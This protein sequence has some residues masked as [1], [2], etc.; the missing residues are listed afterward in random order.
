MAEVR[1][2]N[3]DKLFVK[4]LFGVVLAALIV[5][6]FN[7]GISLFYSSPKY[8]N[9]CSLDVRAVEDPSGK[10][11]K[12]QLTQQDKC[13]KDFDNAYQDYNRMKMFILTP[14]GLVLLI[15]GSFT[16]KLIMQ[17]ML[18]VSG[19]INTVIPLF[20]SRDKISVFVTIAILLVIG[21]LFVLKK[22]RD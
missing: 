5:A 20:E 12:E 3:K 13:S 1:K 18:M 10:L 4:I 8:E 6:F 19:F 9:Y 16:K 17:I 7:V 11:T 15:F 21:I 14:I 2:Q 22:F